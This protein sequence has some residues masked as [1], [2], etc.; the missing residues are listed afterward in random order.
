MK[1][2]RVVVNGNEYK[3]GIE[4][5]IGDKVSTP[6]VKEQIRTAPKPAAPV[7]A[8]AP[9]P[10][11]APMQEGEAAITAPMPGTIINVQKNKGDL[12]AKG[13]VLLVLEAMKMENEIMAPCDGTVST[14][15]VAS[16]ASVN[17]GDVLIEIS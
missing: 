4:E 12:V 16:G 8:A 14:I 15:H 1:N 3:V 5:I 7:K 6:V 11:A 10:T 17:A 13:D 2:F 9:K